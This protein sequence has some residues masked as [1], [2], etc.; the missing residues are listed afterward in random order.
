MEA[1]ISQVGQ[2]VDSECSFAELLEY[3]HTHR[4]FKLTAFNLIR[5]LTHGARVDLRASQELLALLDADLRPERSLEEI[6]ASWRTMLRS[7]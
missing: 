1:V 6:E 5:V 3:L 7:R 4:T 2:M